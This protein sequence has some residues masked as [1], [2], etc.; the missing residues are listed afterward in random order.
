MIVGNLDG[1]GKSKGDSW[2]RFVLRY[3]LFPAI[4]AIAAVTVTVT[5]DELGMLSLVVIWLAVVIIFL[6]VVVANLLLDIRWLR[7]SIGQMGVKS[8]TKEV[9]SGEAL[10]TLVY[11]SDKKVLFAGDILFTN[12]HP[13]LAEGN[14][15]EWAQELDDIKSMAIEKIIPG[16]GPL[17]GK[18]DLDNMKA[19]ILI[20]DQKAKELASRSDNVQKIVTAIQSVLPQRPEGKSM[21][22]PNIQMKYLKK[23]EK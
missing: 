3:G 11:L 22:A 10:D 5:F 2:P 16:H 1:D 9:H 20:F 18:N 8:E 4:A 7:E 14:I 17:S 13:F 23:S 12:Y 6:V 19:Y 15:E 21:I